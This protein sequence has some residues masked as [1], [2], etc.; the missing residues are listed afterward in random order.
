MRYGLCEN[1]N[2]REEQAV[3]DRPKQP[4]LLNWAS[5]T[6]KGNQLVLHVSTRLFSDT[7]LQFQPIQEGLL[8]TPAHKRALHES[9]SVQLRCW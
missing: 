6:G 4:G 9:G 5:F 8:L 7:R 1:E 3:S 2:G